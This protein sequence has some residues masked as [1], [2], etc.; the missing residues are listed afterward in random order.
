MPALVYLNA[1]S[2]NGWDILIVRLK[3]NLVS[4]ELK[5]TKMIYSPITG[6]SIEEAVLMGFS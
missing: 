1:S 2:R 5:M 6:P 4:I 3:L